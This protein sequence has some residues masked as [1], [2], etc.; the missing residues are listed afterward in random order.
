M[1]L[2][3]MDLAALDHLAVV[4]VESIVADCPAAGLQRCDLLRVE[5]V[6]AVDLAALDQLAVVLVDRIATDGHAAGLQRCDLPTCTPLVQARTAVVHVVD[7]VA[8]DDRLAVV[9]VDRVVTD[10]LAS[11]LTCEPLGRALRRGLLSVGLEPVVAMSSCTA[12]SCG[13]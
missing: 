9:L 4:L 2:H 3:I 8:L 1:L 12:R 6:H 5:V 10:G 13:R 7:L 11:G